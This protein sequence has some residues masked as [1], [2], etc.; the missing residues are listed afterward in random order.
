[1]PTTDPDPER[2][3]VHG[4][5]SKRLL[6]VAEFCDRYERSRSRAFELIKSGELLA[7]KDGR[8]TR[9]PVDAAEAWLRKLRRTGGKVSR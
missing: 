2:E 1:M 5:S 8:S 4:T 9:I 6:T 3:C 7:V